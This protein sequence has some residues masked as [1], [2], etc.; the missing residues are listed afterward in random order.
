MC[1]IIKKTHEEIQ[2]L[3]NIPNKMNWLRWYHHNLSEGHCPSNIP[4]KYNIII[5]YEHLQTLI[6][7]LNVK[8][9]LRGWGVTLM[10]TLSVYVWQE[11]SS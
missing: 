8:V 3:Y 5:S 6:C 7:M 9:T 1:E 10:S 4:V 2:F 11:T